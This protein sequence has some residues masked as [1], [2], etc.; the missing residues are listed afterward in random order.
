LITTVDLYNL[1][2]DFLEGRNSD[3]ILK[4]IYETIGEYVYKKV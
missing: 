2:K 1:W 3:E 4:S